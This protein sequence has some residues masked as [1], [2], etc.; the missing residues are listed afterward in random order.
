MPPVYGYPVKISSLGEFV[1]TVF[2]QPF[3]LTHVQT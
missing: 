3:N 1:T 2:F